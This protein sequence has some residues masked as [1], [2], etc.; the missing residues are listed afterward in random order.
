MKKGIDVSHHNGTINWNKVN[1]QFCIVRAGYGREAYQKDLFFEKNYKGCK[2]R[3]IPVGAYWYSYAT[4]VAEAAKEAEVC[5]QVIAG[6]QFEYPIFFDVEEKKQFALGKAA[7]TAIAKAFLERVEKAGYYVGIY[8]SKNGLENYI[9]KSV[10]ERYAVWVANVGVSQTSYRGAAM[11]QYSWTGKHSGISGDVD[12]N[13]CYI[14]YPSIIKSKG[15]NG[16]KAAVNKT[17][18]KSNVKTDTSVNKTVADGKA[19]TSKIAA[20]QKIQLDHMNLYVSSDAPKRSIVLTGF[21]YI[22]DGKIINGRL[23]ITSKPGASVIGWIDRK[24]VKESG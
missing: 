11:W 17:T 13:Y 16:F 6:K 18:D 1:T 19:S 2:A 20:G 22:S 14:D 15:L 4:S 10:R 12:C 24:F 5:L 21:Y 7:C 9:D 3:K 23:R 8:S